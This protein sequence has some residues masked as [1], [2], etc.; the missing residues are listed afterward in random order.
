MKKKKKA[1]RFIGVE[2]EKVTSAP[3]PKKILDLPQQ[4][5]N[6]MESFAFSPG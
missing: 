6:I 2:V 5:I 1:M 3:P 4:T